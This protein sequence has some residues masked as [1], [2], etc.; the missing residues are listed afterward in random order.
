M[1]REKRRAER[2]S[3]DPQ[4]VNK[5]SRVLLYEYARAIIEDK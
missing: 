2:I 4:R 1:A 3:P 5:R